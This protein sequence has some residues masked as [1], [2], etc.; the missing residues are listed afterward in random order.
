MS[1]RTERLFA[2]LEAQKR[3]RIVITGHDNADVDSMASCLLMRRLLERRGIAAE[4]V[5][6]ARAD[7]QSRRVM[8]RMS[9]R[10]WGKR[11]ADSGRPS[12]AAASGARDRLR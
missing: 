7:K 4:I 12:S 10:D 5:L 2:L 1:E 9:R 6:P 8:P 3:G 11:C